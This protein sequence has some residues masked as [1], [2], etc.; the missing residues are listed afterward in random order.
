MAHQHPL[1]ALQPFDDS[2]GGISLPNKRSFQGPW[3]SQQVTLSL[4]IGIASFLAFNF[5]RTKNIALF[6]PRTKLKGFSPPDDGFQSRFFGWIRPTLRTHEMSILHSVGLDAAVLLSFLKMGFWLFFVM[7]AWCCLILMPVNYWQ[8][9]VL[10][11]VSPAEDHRNSTETNGALS[12]LWME[13]FGADRSPRDPPLPQLPLPSPAPHALAYHFTH[14]VSVYLF[15]LLAL[16]AIWK[17]YHKFVRARQLYVLEILDSIPARTV[18][19]RDLPLHL[20]DDR[21]LAEYF[22]NMDMRVESTAVVRKVGGLSKL[23][24]ARANALNRLENAWVEWLGNPTDAEGYDPEKI[25]LL[26]ASAYH[27][28]SSMEG[29]EAGRRDRSADAAHDEEALLRPSQQTSTLN[30]SGADT[31]RTKKARPTMRKKWWNPFSE[32]VDALGELTRRF[33]ELDRA[34]R[35][36]RKAGCF[37]GSK[38]GFVTFENAASAQI[39]SQTVHYPIPAHCRTKMAPEPRDIIWSNVDL[40]NTDRRARQVVVSICMILLLIFYIPPLIFLASFLSPGAIKKYLPW[41]DR[42]LGTNARLRALVQ[43]NLPSLVLIGFNNLLPLILEWSA[44]VQG[45]R[46]RSLVEYSVMKKYYLFLVVSVV[47]VFLITTTAWGVL[48]ELAQNPARLIDKLAASLPGA[49]FFSLSYVIVTGVA[50]QP[51]Q[52]LQLPTLLLRGFY[53]LFLTRTPREFAEL[54]APPMLVMGTIYP[55]ALL[56]FTLSILY[57]IVSPL[58][59][60]FGALYFGL[61]Y[62]V[63]KYKLLYVFYKPYESQG[64]A[65]PISARRCIWALVL[66]HIFQFSVFSVRKQLVAS[67]MVVPLVVFTVWFGYHLERT[68]GP[69][70]THIN[71]SSII[72]ASKGDAEATGHEGGEEAEHQT[73]AEAE[74]RSQRRKQASKRKSRAEAEDETLFVAE[75]DAKTDYRE[76]PG[77]DHYPGVLNTGRR[78]YG[79]PALSGILPDLWLPIPRAPLSTL[80]TD[81]EALPPLEAA[82]AHH[83]AHTHAQPL[84]LS[85]RHRKPSTTSSSTSRSHLVLGSDGIAG[86]QGSSSQAA[87]GETLSG[88]NAVAPAR[89]ASA[90][91]QD[92][93]EEGVYMHRRSRIG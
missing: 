62:V 54:H 50:L 93:E 90:V 70:S 19:I 46:T 3:F 22:E 84:I 14:L 33:N 80:P 21:E 64:Q 82:K 30:I 15:T 67:L 76:P 66:F 85:L 11:G 74:A 23:L 59:C 7:S 71:L 26:T 29:V 53:R 51:V 39:A 38:V 57:S 8:N 18:E 91:E 16:R 17:N 75:Q 92:E 28:D 44:V 58:I 73:T 55:Q 35:Q 72:E 86:P 63:T 88:N 10:D 40:S 60:I 31:I 45:L 42:L 77:S 68:F 89:F 32:K 27:D 9:G 87:L 37:A 61:A 25:M 81:P 5:L 65:W 13:A 2:D 47:F 1:F 6:A 12:T 79:H 36:R 83:R 41:L 24:T 20:R 34:V 78:R 48:Q 4:S 52:L 49:R 56:I 43:N 69:L